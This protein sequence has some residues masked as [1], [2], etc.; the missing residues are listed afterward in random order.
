[1]FTLKCA[2]KNDIMQVVNDRHKEVGMCLI[3]L[4]NPNGVSIRTEAVMDNDTC[5]WVVIDSAGEQIEDP[6]YGKLCLNF[7]TIVPLENNLSV[8]ELWTQFR[9]ER[10]SFMLGL[11]VPLKLRGIQRTCSDK[12]IEFEK[13]RPGDVLPN[14]PDSHNK[15]S[16][17]SSGGMSFTFGEGNY[18]P[19]TSMQKDIGIRI[20]NMASNFTEDTNAYTRTLEDMGIG[21][22][23]DRAYRDSS[24]VSRSPPVRDLGNRPI[25]INSNVDNEINTDRVLLSMMTF[26]IGLAVMILMFKFKK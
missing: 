12:I 23:P 18:S 14:I 25:K 7:I 4:G 10:I 8:I 16:T 11:T 1:M 24:I 3:Y 15:C 5:S 22:L 17:M 13:L 20:V 19:Y 9:H 2:S 26:L 21:I 6:L